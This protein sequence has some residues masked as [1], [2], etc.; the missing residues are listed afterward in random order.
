MIIR[1]CALCMGSYIFACH[2]YSLLKTNKGVYH[3]N[4]DFRH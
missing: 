4:L 3:G 2:T 1:A